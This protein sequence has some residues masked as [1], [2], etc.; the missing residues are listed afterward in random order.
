LVQ[1]VFKL[2]IFKLKIGKLRRC[3]S[4]ILANLA[5]LGWQYRGPSPC[6]I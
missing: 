3:F 5:I 1:E 2:K 6:M 4:A